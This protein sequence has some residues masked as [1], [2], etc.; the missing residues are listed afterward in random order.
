[1]YVFPDSGAIQ[2]QVNGLVSMSR[3]ITPL[4]FLVQITATIQDLSCTYLTFIQNHI[5]AS[6][7]SLFDFV[8]TTR[9]ETEWKSSARHP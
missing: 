6:L 3:T 8:I 2:P 1:M 7:G 5:D 9:A 4:D